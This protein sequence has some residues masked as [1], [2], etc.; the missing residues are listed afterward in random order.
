MMEKKQKQKQKF[1]LKILKIYNNV[2]NLQK[3]AEDFVFFLVIW[4]N[5]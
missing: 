2:L 1:V 4:G 5:L 3:Q